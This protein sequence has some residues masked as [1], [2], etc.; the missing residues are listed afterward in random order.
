MRRK[1]RSR[2]RVFIA[3]IIFSAVLIVFVPL[4]AYGASNKTIKIG[5]SAP[6]KFAIGQHIAKG[7]EMAADEI[8]ANGGVMISGERYD[9]EVIS[10]D[11]NCFLS[12]SD[13]VS[14]IERLITVQKVNF[15]LGGYSSQGTLAQQEVMAD[16]KIIYI[17]TGGTHPELN[18]RV[19]KD[20][21]RYK[22]WFRI[23]LCSSPQTLSYFA[24]I[25]PIIKKVKAELGVEKPQVALLM[26]KAIW[27]DPIAEIARKL[28]SA[29][30]CEVI[31]EWRPSVQATNLTAEYAAIR[32]AGAHIIFQVSAGPVGGIYGKQWGELKI[33]A[34]LIGVNVEAGKQS[35]WEATRG[36]NNY[37][38]T[39][40]SARVAITEKSLPFWEKFVERYGEDPL[41]T[42]NINYDALFYLKDAIEEAGTLDSDTLIPILEKT[43]YIGTIGRVSFTPRD[44]ER[45]HDLIFGPDYVFM[46]GCQWRDGKLVA[47]WP[48][49]NEIHPAVIAAGAP[50]GWDKIKIEDL[51]EYEI[52]PWVKEY[53]KNKK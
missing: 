34:C 6:L 36:K 53:W 16:N 40:A 24:Q 15:V 18:V 1:V 2:I 11:D 45:P 32:S 8:N 49:G 13:A 29:M 19:A 41:Y 5:V 26:D 30:G 3:F 22:Y 23:W 9:Y 35:H 31:G 44:H 38:Q 21:D 47:I 50:T 25:T 43:D 20:Y 27:I 42:A 37:E 46:T 28:F 17:A 12:V 52:P 14:A 7:A 4:G 51:V 33:P 39:S 48:D 10:I